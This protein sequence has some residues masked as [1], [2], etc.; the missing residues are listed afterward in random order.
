MLVD[1]DGGELL[2]EMNFVTPHLADLPGLAEDC[3]AEEE[4]QDSERALRDLVDLL[5]QPSSRLEGRGGADPDPQGLIDGIGAVPESR[6]GR[7]SEPETI[8]GLIGDGKWRRLKVG[9]TMDS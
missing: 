5:M 8:P 6:P 7:K 9:V 1:G 2:D 3:A 4:D